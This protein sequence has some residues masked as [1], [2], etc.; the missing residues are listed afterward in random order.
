MN[1]YYYHILDIILKSAY[2]LH[3][4]EHYIITKYN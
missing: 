3:L 1:K 4:L 2:S